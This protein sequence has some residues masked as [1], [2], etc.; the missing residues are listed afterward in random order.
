MINGTGTTRKVVY[1]LAHVMVVVVCG[2]S[3]MSL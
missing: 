1:S 3:V 2:D